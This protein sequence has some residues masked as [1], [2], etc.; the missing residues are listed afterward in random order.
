VERYVAYDS[1]AGRQRDGLN[2]ET[3]IW[4]RETTDQICRLERANHLEPSAVCE[5]R[6]RAL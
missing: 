1:I 4:R 5:R 3:A 2:A 6:R